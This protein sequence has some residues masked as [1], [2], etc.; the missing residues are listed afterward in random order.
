MIPTH[1]TR[2]LWGFAADLVDPDGNVFTI[3]ETR[4][5]SATTDWAKAGK[6]A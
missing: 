4:K 3:H 1:V 2:G 6:K 5:L